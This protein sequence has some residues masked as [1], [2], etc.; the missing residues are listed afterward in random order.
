MTQSFSRRRFLR[1]AGLL[2]L[3][4]AAG[5][6]ATP[7]IARGAASQIRIVSNPGLENATLN[8]LMDE[9]GYFRRFGVNAM[10]AQI[11]GATGPF[12]AIAAGAADVCMVSGYNMVLS[13]IAQG[14]RVKIVGAG[15]KKCA[16]T[17]FARPDGIKTLADLKGKT[18]AVG[19]TS[20]L[21]HTLMLQ[22][23]KEKGLDASQINF[24]DKGSNDQCYEAVVKN[25]ADACCASISH[26]NDG[27]GLVVID[28]GNMW[29][30]LPGCI[31]QTA[32]ASDAA[33]RDKHEGLVA[34]M[35]AYGALYDYL[36]SPA[37]HDAFF[38]ARKRAQKHFDKASAQAIWDFN[39]AQRPYSKD[40]SLTSGEIGYLQD[41][42]IALGSLK[43]KQPFAEVADMS[44]AQAAAK[45][46]T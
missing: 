3:S 28:E 45:L 4:V 43:Q 40:L 23:M 12:D 46:V 8:A 24:V 14:A 41:M 16:L 27:D 33:L 25:E 6:L 37:S 2:G 26:L 17:V 10:I 32:Y 31:F 30:A 34:I 20:G 22:L 36:M 19:P 7:F 13:R 15:M 44:A 1:G 35:A 39:Q 18:V 5:G 29:Q 42:F 38:E 11:P 21:L 9:L